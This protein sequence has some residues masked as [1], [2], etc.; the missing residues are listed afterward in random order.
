MLVLFLS[1]HI[2]EV[3]TKYAVMYSA[4]HRSHNFASCIGEMMMSVGILSLSGYGSVSRQRMYWSEELDTRNELIVRSMRRNR[5][6]KMIKYIHTADNDDL[7]MDDRFSKI[8]PLVNVLN[9]KFLEFGTVIEPCKVSIDK[10]MIPNFGRLHTKQFFR[11]KPKRSDYAAW[12]AA[13][14]SC[15]AFYLDL[16]DGIEAGGN[17]SYKKV[18]VW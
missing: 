18:R 12:V 6:D 3:S 15:Y 11:G 8:R 5:F 13:S 7:C 10:S 14:P 17:E 1:E 16:Y 9:E 4:Q 2:F